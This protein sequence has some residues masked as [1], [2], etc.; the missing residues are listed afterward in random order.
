[1]IC[2]ICA[3]S[4]LLVGYCEHYGVH[5]FKLTSL[6]CCHN[7]W[8]AKWSLLYSFSRN[9]E[10]ILVVRMERTNNKFITISSLHVISQKVCAGL[11][12]PNMV[13]PYHSILLVNSWRN[14]S[15]EHSSGIQDLHCKVLRWCTRSCREQYVGALR[16]I[17]TDQL[18][19]WK[20]AQYKW[21]LHLTSF[22]GCFNVCFTVWSR[23]NS[24]S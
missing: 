18:N 8:I 24:N 21:F 5:L 11:I 23:T 17:H 10:L 7:H 22:Q 13:I 4:T 16:L 1:M 2:F 15:Q 20:P 14:P 6:L 9:G 12:L 3:S 19:R